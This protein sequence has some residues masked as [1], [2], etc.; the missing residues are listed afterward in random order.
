MKV[1]FHASVSQKNLY[2]KN[3]KRIDRTLREMKFEVNSI[4]P[5][6]HKLD[7]LLKEDKE[8]L[9]S[10]YYQNML[11]RVM[12]ADIVVCEISFPSTI[13]TGH[14]LTRALERGKSVLGLYHENT[15]AALL[16]GL[17]TER[18]LVVAY[19]D[20]NLE[21]VLQKGIQELLNMPDQRFTMLLP[22]NIVSHLDR[23]A[24]SEI[25][26]LEYI[27]KLIMEK[28]EKIK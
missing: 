2:G 8:G 20:L 23:I 26:R 13:V 19:N 14:V 3:Y 9:I 6:K 10:K 27:R 5:L 16:A 17:E 15:T 11:H 21:K 25:T 1:Y 28:M 24:D 7:K 12:W 18:F 22:K 4:H